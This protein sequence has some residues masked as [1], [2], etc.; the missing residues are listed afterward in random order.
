MNFWI[1]SRKLII[2]N[3]LLTLLYFFAFHNVIAIQEEDSIRFASLQQKIN[4]Y[5]LKDYSIALE[6]ALEAL[7]IAEANDSDYMLASANKKLGILYWVNGYYYKSI[8]CLDNA[9]DYFT[10]IDDKKSAASSIHIKALNYY[11]MASYDSAISFHNQS[12]DI[13]KRIGD[14]REIARVLS[15]LS[16]VY[17]KRGE[18]AKAVENILEANRIR[19]EF[20]DP[21]STYNLKSSN[22]AFRNI[23]YYNDE[24]KFRLNNLAKAEEENN[25]SKIASIKTN[26]GRTY[27]LLED[28]ENA[29]RYFNESNSIYD[30]LGQIPFMNETAK[31]LRDMNRYEEALDILAKHAILIGKRGTRITLSEIRKLQGEIYFKMGNFRKSIEYYDIYYD[32]SSEMRNRLAMAQ[33]LERLGEDYFEL[34]DYA[35]AR[36]YQLGSLSLAKEIG[37]IEPQRKSLASLAKIESYS[38]NYKLAFEY[39]NEYAELTNLINEGEASIS[40]VHAQAEYESFK[41]AEEI[42]KL[43]I[44]NLNQEHRAKNLR[45]L[46]ISIIIFLVLTASLTV[47]IYKRYKFEAKASSLLEGK[48]KRI[49]LL[50]GEIHH[51]VKNNLQLINS[52]LNIQFHKL[53]SQRAKQAV[54]EGKNMVQTMG[55]IHENLYRS[56]EPGEVDMSKYFE[57]LSDNLKL[58]Y[59]Y[60]DMN[61]NIDTHNIQLDI[62]TVIPLGLIA[63]EL[64]TNSMKHAFKDVGSPVIDIDLKKNENQLIFEVSDN[65]IGNTETQNGN[66]FGLSLVKEMTN[67]MNGELSI[68]TNNGTRTTITINNF[69]NRENNG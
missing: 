59:G 31:A 64:L 18:Y 40:M 61:I 29:L 12:L 67:R 42:N 58:C 46:A 69:N 21:V 65:G 34:N 68:D 32:M 35:S 25:L 15:H 10:R 41:N 44:E 33:V 16:L 6:Y 37:A 27:N 49:E 36:D 20:T 50:L 57:D 62:D 38:G 8:A 17:H 24:L 63:N 3:V 53:E 55:L 52:L 14:K 54:I 48:N 51:R 43:K 60:Q 5:D 7:K 47:I 45:L 30:S 28:H 22:P 19:S 9:F 1:Q 13:Y 66:S 26:I 2:K 56:N 11:Y 4:E 39:K 23:D